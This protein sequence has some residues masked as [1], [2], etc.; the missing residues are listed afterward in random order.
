MN[1]NLYDLKQNMEITHRALKSL[2]SKWSLLLVKLNE[3]R[4][5]LIGFCIH[6]NPTL[7]SLKGLLILGRSLQLF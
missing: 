5:G 3:I 1:I 6:I 2:R 7:A 4:V